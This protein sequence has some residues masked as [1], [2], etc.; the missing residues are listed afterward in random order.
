MAPTL[1]DLLTQF[2]R[3]RKYL[4]NVSPR[5]LE[6]YETAWQAFRRSATHCLTDAGSLTRADLEHFVYA[7]RDRGVRPVTCNTWLRALNAFFKWMHERGDLPSR[8]HMRPLKV[9]K[10]LV[11]TIEPE[12]IRV[13]AGFKPPTA[14]TVNPKHQDGPRKG[15]KAFA[16][17]RI[18]AL[19]CALLDTGCRVQELLD[20]HVEHFDF[21]DLLVTVV[22][23]GDK[24]RRIP[25]S[26]E[27]RRVLYRHIEQRERFGVPKHEPFM[28]P[29]HE[30]SS[31]SA[32]TASVTRSRRSICVGVVMWFACR[33]RWGIPKSPRRCATCTCSL[34]I[35][36]QCTRGCRRSADF[37]RR[38]QSLPAVPGVSFVPA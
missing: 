21:D 7:T 34:T 27:L 32:S 36:K 17:W 35:C 15:Q 3:E 25:F 11:P 26:I 5:T 22:G 6:W 19:T 16:L 20:A 2:L 18:H 29:A 10:R 30:G 24:Q 12:A 23:K 38:H 9:E 13:L 4:R 14:I 33:A 31:A 37:G 28:F 1:D 8:V